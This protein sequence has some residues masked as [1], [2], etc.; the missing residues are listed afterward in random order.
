[1]TNSKSAG[2]EPLARWLDLMRATFDTQ[3]RLGKEYADVA[4][5]AFRRDADQ[6]EMGRAYLKSVQRETEQYWRSM[7]TLWLNYASDVLAAGSRASHSVLHDVGGAA[8]PRH[9]HDG[10]T[11][12]AAAKP[13]A[14]LLSGPLGAS[15][16]GTVTVANKHPDARR[17]VL[18]PGPLRDASGQ[19][20]A[21]EIAVK[22]KTIQLEPGAERNVTV[23]VDL[24][25]VALSAD[26]TYESTI[27]V[28]GGEEAEIRVT[29]RPQA[30]K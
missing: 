9:R 20:V 21:G 10:E 1:M 18:K 5:A 26:Q 24:D 22:P 11:A 17:L 14:L 15:A 12:S 19:P 16:S 27:E 25:A 2:N 29:V 30:A 28:T 3:V 7:S 13:L 6:G 8:H 4:R 23:S